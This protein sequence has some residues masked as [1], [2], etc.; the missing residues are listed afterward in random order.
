MTLSYCGACGA[1]SLYFNV[2]FTLL[3]GNF[4]SFIYGPSYFLSCEVPIGDFAWFSIALFERLTLFYC[5]DVNCLV[6]LISLEPVLGF[7]LCLYG[8]HG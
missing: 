1:I 7:R 2:Y 5:D 3:R 4:F 8:Y 6:N